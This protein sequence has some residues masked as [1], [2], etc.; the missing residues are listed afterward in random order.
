MEKIFLVVD[1]NI[2][3]SYFL[4][5]GKVKE[6]IDNKAVVLYAPDWAKYE[7]EKYSNLIK[8]K[9]KLKNISEAE[10]DILLLEL[11][12]KV[13]IVHKSFYQNKLKEAFQICKN[14]DEKDT[15]FVALAL[16][17]NLPIWTNDKKMLS[18]ADKTNKFMT[19]S[20]KELVKMLKSKET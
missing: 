15:P 4:V 17:L 1:T 12:K 18:Y 16:K 2:L 11:Y 20:T 7:L 3:F 8:A 14:F 13:I 19:I 6:I 10:I 9:A 5:K